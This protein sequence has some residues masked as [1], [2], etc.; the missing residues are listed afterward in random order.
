MAER[1]DL[2]DFVVG[3]PAENRILVLDSSLYLPKL[4]RAFPN[5]EL[6]A[7]T[8]YE[9][10]PDFSEYRDLGVHWTVQDYRKGGLPYELRFFD[11]ILSESCMECLWDSYDT[12]LDISRHIK[13]TGHFLGMFSNVRYWRIL[14]GL[15]QGE[16]PVRDRHL[17]AKT[18]A[19]RILN[20]ALFKEIFFIPSEFCEEEREQA[21][22][23]EALGFLDGED[24]LVKTWSF[25][26][27]CSK[28]S[29]AAL[30]E[31]YTPEVRTLLARL[32]HRI[33][34]DVEREESLRMLWELCRKEM[35]FPEYLSDFLEE[36]VVQ[37]EQMRK[38]LA[39]SA[40]ENG[41]DEM[42]NRFC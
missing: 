26:A 12:L 18:E 17:Y 38:A 40:E 23:L 37:K 16:F 15:R 11:M 1:H 2:M 3:G 42:R 8:V 36:I 14:E 30:K 29:V 9:E 4:R 27:S 20:D 39:R 13:E 19:V 35:I 7:M 34:Y 32:L 6:Y 41:M 28:A 24:L 10:V 25:R 21:E 33:E 5:A 31:F 22:S